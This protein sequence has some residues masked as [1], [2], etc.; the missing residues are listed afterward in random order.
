SIYQSPD[1]I[2]QNLIGSVLSTD[3]AE[4]SVK[5]I[6]KKT[7]KDSKYFNLHSPTTQREIMKAGADGKIGIGLHSNSVTINSIF[8][9][10]PFD[11]KKYPSGVRAY[12]NVAKD[13]TYVTYNI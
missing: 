13:G 3:F 12:K 1:N 9:Q 10:V 2:V 5:M 6:D 4:D 7:A 8:Q 11:E